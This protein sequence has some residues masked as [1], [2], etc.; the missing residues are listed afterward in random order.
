MY[1]KEERLISSFFMPIIIN[2]R[3]ILVVAYI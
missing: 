1:K 3:L 2:D